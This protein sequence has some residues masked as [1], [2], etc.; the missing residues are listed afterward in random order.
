MR[1]LILALVT[2][3]PVFAHLNDD[4]SCKPF[5]EVVCS[6]TVINNENACRESKLD[7]TVNSFKLKRN[8]L[9]YVA[10]ISPIH[11]VINNF[12]KS[13]LK[14]EIQMRLIEPAPT[15]NPPQKYFFIDELINF[16]EDIEISYAKH[17]SAYAIL[18]T[19]RHPHTL[20]FIYGEDGID[21]RTNIL[22]SLCDDA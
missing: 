14:K 9:G 15:G 5:K 4:L 13:R 3:L 16:F 17:L 22:Y 8:N 19:Q 12:N 1:I 7:R 6:L 2:S 11:D 10:N 20:Q 18:S 21:T